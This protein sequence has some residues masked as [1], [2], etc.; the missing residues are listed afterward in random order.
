MFT[1]LLAAMMAGLSL[2]LAVFLAAGF[3]SLKLHG[4]LLITVYLIYL[5]MAFLVEL[6][7]V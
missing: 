4:V 3:R 1:L 2:T 5:L 7:V 6:H